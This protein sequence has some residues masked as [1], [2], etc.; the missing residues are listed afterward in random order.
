[1]PFIIIPYLIRVGGTNF[2][3]LVYKQQDLQ[4]KTQWL[5]SFFLFLHLNR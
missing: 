3:C 2:C 4:V 5:S 1:M